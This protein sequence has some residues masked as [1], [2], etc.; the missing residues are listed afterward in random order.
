M[1]THHLCSLTVE[2]PL[3]RVAGDVHL[4]GTAH[5]NADTRTACGLANKG[6]AKEMCVRLFVVSD[7]FR[8][9]RMQASCVEK[10]NFM[11]NPRGRAAGLELWM[12]TIPLDLAQLE[13]RAFD[14]K[15]RYPVDPWDFL[16][17]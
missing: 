5:D 6:K 12:G 3:V 13:A 1:Y 17:F 2:Y 9:E 16:P 10:D 7:F 8:D 14:F 4:C 15:R 11:I